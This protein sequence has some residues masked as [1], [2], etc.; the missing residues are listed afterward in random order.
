MKMKRIENAHKILSAEAYERY[1][2]SDL[3]IG[4]NGECYSL[5]ANSDMSENNLIRGE[6]NVE[7]L[8]ALIID[9]CAESDTEQ[10]IDDAFDYVLTT[11]GGL[12][13]EPSASEIDCIANDYVSSKYPDLSHSEIHEIVNAVDALMAD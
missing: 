4:F 7:L 11:V 5:F 1:I 13:Y 6:L 12:N 3:C 9:V 8:D 10:I 2:N